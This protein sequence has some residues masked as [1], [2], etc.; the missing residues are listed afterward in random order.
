MKV[1]II[2]R[3]TLYSVPGGDTIQAVE[4][5]RHLTDMGVDTEVKLSN[6]EIIYNDY[7]LLHF[8]NIIRPADMLHQCLFGVLTGD[9][10]EVGRCNLHVQF[11]PNLHIRFDPASVEN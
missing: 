4:T 9:A 6:E 7:D 10:P 2:A 5:A 8:F 11:L 1:A 3:S